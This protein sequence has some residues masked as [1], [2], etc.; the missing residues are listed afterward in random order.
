MFSFGP[1]PTRAK[2]AWSSSTCLL[3]DINH[4]YKNRK[5]KKTTCQC[6]WKRRKRE[7]DGEAKTNS[8]EKERKETG[9]RKGED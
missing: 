2:K 8:K 6:L 3:Y 7:R 1:S 9:K 5:Y 4:P